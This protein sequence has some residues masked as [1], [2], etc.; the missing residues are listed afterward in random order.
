MATSSAISNVICVV[1]FDG[2][3]GEIKKLTEGTFA[4]IIDMRK[5][6]LNLSSSY[7]EFTEVAKKSFEFIDE[8]DE[9]T[10]LV[11]ETCGYHLDCYRTFTNISKLER[12]NT[13]LANAGRK[14]VSEQSIGQPEINSNARKVARTTRHSL[15][16]LKKVKDCPSTCRSSNVLPEIC[17]ICKRPGALYITDKVFLSVSFAISFNI[18]YFEWK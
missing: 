13:T 16:T 6:W 5:R 4:K 10:E 2:K 9:L 3:N 17:L 18:G 7:K 12:A 15:S 14:R 11:H 1:H 8:S